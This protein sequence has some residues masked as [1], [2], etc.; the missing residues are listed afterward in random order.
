MKV[1]I[2]CKKFPYPLKEGEPIAITYLA[3][4][5]CLKGCAV[6]LCVLNTTKHYFDPEQLPENEN[7]YH[8]I[9]S[10]K[11]SN[12]I[13][14]AGAAKSMLTGQSYILSRFYSKEYEK[15]LTDILSKEQFDIVQLE[16]IYMAHYIP[17][18]RK[19][20]EAV[21]ALRTHNVEHLIWQRVAETTPSFL[22]SFY[23]QY[24]NMSLRKFE[25]KHLND[26]DVLVAITKKDLEIFTALGFDQKSVVAPVGINMN[27][28]IF[29]NGKKA[30]PM[31]VAFIGALDWM[32][33]Q[34]GVV[35]FLDNVWPLLSEKFPN[36][37]FHIAGKNTP[38]WIFKK[39]AKRVVVHGEVPDAKKFIKSSPILIAPLF[40]GSGI[41]IKVL[42]GMA[43]GRVVITTSIGAE[44]IPAVDGKHLLVADDAKSFF[45]TIKLCFEDKSKVDNIGNAGIELIKSEFNNEVIAQNVIDAYQKFRTEN[46]KREFN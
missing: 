38:D 17:T 34:D 39:A 44:G 9:Y 30:E 31:S 4:A 14:V 26:C 18:V 23:L 11:V 35:W 19:Y 13:T 43:M 3:R 1:L 25:L 8:K 41:K 16:T 10:V 7:F 5:L 46:Q 24:Q 6:T 12:Y 20:S 33:N 37:T 15:K 27:D 29:E 22:R 36:A 42:E 28:Y 40:S 2:L 45:S 32:P 21:I